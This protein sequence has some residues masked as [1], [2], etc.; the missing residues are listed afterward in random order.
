MSSKSADLLPVYASWPITARL[1]ALYALMSAVILALA[2]GILYFA[3]VRSLEQAGEQFLGD[4]VGVLRDILRKPDYERARLEEEVQLEVAAYQFTQYFARVLAPDGEVIIETPGME[5]ALP[6]SLFHGSI[7]TSVAPEGFYRQGP[8]RRQYLLM[9]AAAGSL[10]ASHTLHVGLDLSQQAALLA[11]YRRTLLLVL[12]LGVFGA[13]VA[14]AVVAWQGLRPLRRITD[15]VEQ[16]TASQL[17]TRIS[18]QGWPRELVT[19]AA[20]FDAMMDRLEQ[21]FDRLSRF[22]A[23]LAHELRTPIGNL[24]GE[25]EVALARTRTPEEYQQVLASSLEEYGRLA[26]LIESLLFLAR[27]ENTEVSARRSDLDAREVARSVRDF[28]EAVAE[29]QIV[30]VE[31]HGQARLRGDPV[32]VR[33]ALSNL[34]GNALQHTPPGGSVEIAI[35]AAEGEVVIRIYDTGEGIAPEH[36][37]HLFDR[38]YRVDEAR[39]QPAEGTGL[40]LAIVKSIM[41]LHGGRVRIESTPGEGTLITLCFP[42][43]SHATAPT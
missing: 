34:L 2:I 25:A 13:A 6:R 20:A 1:A 18:R 8:S 10:D 24:M 32:L 42:Q 30:R 27:A 31:V 11:D 5:Q 33:R 17:H 41:D 4:K 3:L 16:V 19:L 7:S 37:P 15:R 38:F 40:G 14:G 35:E 23:D 28:Y 21:A 9:T 12:V 26:R 43:E 29:E 22:S 36:L 39:A